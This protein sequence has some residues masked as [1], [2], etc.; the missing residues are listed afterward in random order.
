MLRYCGGVGALRCL[1]P[2]GSQTPGSHAS[3]CL[4][5]ARLIAVI[6]HYPLDCQDGIRG[7]KYLAVVAESNTW[8]LLRSQPPGGLLRS[9]IPD[10]CGGVRHSA[11]PE[12][13]SDSRRVS[14][15]E[16]GNHCPRRHGDTRPHRPET[17]RLP[18]SVCFSLPVNPHFLHAPGLRYIVET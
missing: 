1:T 13:V 4:K 18:A 7:V 2:Y 15:T 17:W 10:A 9:Q 3:A 6:T 16:A 12:Q 11:V 14:D 5:T 8:R